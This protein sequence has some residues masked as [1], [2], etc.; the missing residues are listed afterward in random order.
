MNKWPRIKNQ[1]GLAMLFTCDILTLAF[2]FYLSFLIRRDFLPRIFE[3]L[4]PFNQ[5]IKSYW[6]IFLIWIG[7]FIY[8]DGYSKRFAFW[9][10]IKFLWQSVFTSLVLIVT[11]LFIS[12]KG[13][14]FSRILIFTMTLL[15]FPIF[16]LAR[17]FIKRTLYK[18]GLMRRK[19]LILGSGEAAKRALSAV[20]NEPNLGYEVAGFIDDSPKT[21]KIDGIKIHLGLK[22]IERY[23]K[24]AGIHDVIIAKP[25]LNKKRLASL[26]SHVQHK[27]ENTLFLPDID[28]IA[29]TET[30]LRYFFQEQTII[31]E[32]Q[33]NLS[34]PLIY[35]TKRLIDY[36]LGAF[37]F[38]FLFPLML[39]ISAAIKFTSKGP[40]FFVQQ[41]IGKKGKL[42]KCYK[43][44]TMYSNAEEKLEELLNEN[45]KAKNE[46]NKYWKLKNDPRITSVGRFLRKTSLD[47]L[48]Q[49]INVLKGEMSLIGPRPYL[50][51]EWNYIREES[52]I[53]HALPPGIT[54]LWQVSGRNEKDYN[55]RIAMDSWYVKNWSLWLDIV[56]LFK[57]I[58]AIIK[59]EGAC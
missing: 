44:R 23:V 47:E 52:E 19:I 13:P 55:F 17:L 46:W 45:E 8:K 54:G 20:R 18:L 56:I 34:K 5:D 16:P 2:L 29:V 36:F 1:I 35:L 53:I 10:E 7:V 50:P 58:R 42:F 28:G 39:L 51:R 12:K 25:E 24:S 11:I 57:T 9:D 49:V 14:E 37:V 21:K 38:I 43:F 22:Q 15:A 59:K 41:R 30:E 3:T 32:I 48:P 40:V 31:I 33:N 27:V 26:I 6:W 4:S